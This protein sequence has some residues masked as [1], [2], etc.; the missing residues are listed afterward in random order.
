MLLYVKQLFVH[1]IITHTSYVVYAEIVSY[2]ANIKYHMT[3]YGYDLQN[4]K[5]LPPSCFL[6]YF[7][8][9]YY[10]FPCFFFYLSVCCFSI[11]YN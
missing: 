3:I 10:F 2:I 9:I 1:N 4:I 7:Y 11:I 6:N 8:N 5:E